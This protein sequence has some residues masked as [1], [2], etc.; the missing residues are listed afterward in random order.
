MS[1]LRRNIEPFYELARTGPILKKL[2]KKYAG[3]RVIGISDLFE[4]LTWAII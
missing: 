2:L 4:S 1:D 3:Y